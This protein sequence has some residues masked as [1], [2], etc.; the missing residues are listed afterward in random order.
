MVAISDII[1]E[2]QGIGNQAVW[3]LGYRPIRS[4]GGTGG[5]VLLHDGIVYRVA[6]EHG[7]I[8]C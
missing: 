7:G 4:H 2:L 1:L 8:W 6:I 5:K 3:S